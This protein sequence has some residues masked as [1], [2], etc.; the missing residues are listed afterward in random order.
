MDALCVTIAT[1]T[2]P[3]ST[4]VQ[5]TNYLV[6][7][8]VQSTIS[9]VCSTGTGVRTSTYPLMAGDFVQLPTINAGQQLAFFLAANMNSS[10]TPSNVFYNGASNN[11]DGYQHLVAFFP[12]NNS[13]YIII[14]FEDL[15]V[16]GSDKDCNDAMF[17]IDVGPLNAAA[18]RSASTL[19]K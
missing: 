2:A 9:P 12:D 17:V 3:T 6:F 5:G 7:P 14:G 16:P 8:L 4:E 18:L 15:S 10:G 11:T 13:Q 1:V 19:P